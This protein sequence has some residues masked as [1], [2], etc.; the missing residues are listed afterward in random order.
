MLVATIATRRRRFS[1]MVVN[2]KP[3][4]FLPS[5]ALTHS[6]SH[7]LADSRFLSYFVLLGL[8]NWDLGT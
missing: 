8:V 1:V 2:V 3:I 4:S 5:S 7:P 6:L